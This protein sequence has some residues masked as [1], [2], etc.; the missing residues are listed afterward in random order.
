MNPNFCKFVFPANVSPDLLEGLVGLAVLKAERIFGRARTRIYAS[1]TLARTP[2]CCVIDTSSKVGR[3]VAEAF[4]ALALQFTG[5]DFT[6][7]RL[8]KWEP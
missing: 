1:Y 6:V 2:P 8:D 7:V 4:V 3:F 5:G